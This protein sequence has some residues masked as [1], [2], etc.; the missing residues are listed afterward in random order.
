MGKQKHHSLYGQVIQRSNLAKAWWAVK[1]NHGAAGVD[2]QSINQFDANADAELTQL[3]QELRAKT[4]QPQPVRRVYIPKADGSQ[5]PLGIPAVRDRVVQQ[6]LRQVMEPVFEPLFLDCSFGF[7]PGKGALMAIDRVSAHL[8]QG[9]RWVV[10]CDVKGYFDSIPHEKLI[11]AVAEEVADGTVLRLIRAFLQAGAL[12]DGIYSE[13]RAGTPQGGVISPLLANV[14]LHKLDLEM[15]LRG[16]RLTRYADDFVVLVGSERA[17]LRVME[18]VKNLLEKELGLTVHPDKSRVVNVRD[19]FE[20]LGYLFKASDR[21]PKDKAIDELKDAV[22]Q[23]TSR[24]QTT[25]IQAVIARLNPVLRGWGNYFCHGRVR[26]RFREIDEWI[27]RR[28]RAVQ[29]RSWRYVGQIHRVLR[30]LGEK[31]QLVYLR[32]TRWASSTHWMATAAIPNSL[33]VSL[34]L[35]SLEAIHVRTLA[36]R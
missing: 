22:R 5:R 15:T 12:E 24:N 6:A 25:T 20:F 27:R 21:R 29:L 8:K 4:Y 23:V 7:R 34:G 9:Y 32:M 16:H 28:L 33:F 30:R 17:A 13:S 35:V 14:Y 31:R 18:A 3:E 2:H 36:A 1:A 10:D 26:K 11:D 19:G